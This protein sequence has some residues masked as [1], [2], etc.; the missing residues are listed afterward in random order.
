MPRSRRWWAERRDHWRTPTVAADQPS[1]PSSCPQFTAEQM[2]QQLANDP[3]F[4]QWRAEERAAE[5]AVLTLRAYTDPS[6]RR[7]RG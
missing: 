4:I 2:A 1:T 5:L 6:D 3:E 7:H